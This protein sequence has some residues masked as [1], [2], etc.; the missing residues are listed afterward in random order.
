MIYLRL[1][2]SEAQRLVGRKAPREYTALRPRPAGSRPDAPGKSGAVYDRL[3]TEPNW[4]TVECFDARG[5]QAETV[6]EIHR[7]V[8]AAVDLAAFCP[9]RSPKVAYKSECTC[10]ADTM[11]FSEFL[12]NTRS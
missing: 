2:A 5:G 12:G 1:G 11:P 6:E 10:F 9:S 4:V 3:A 8:L 7:D